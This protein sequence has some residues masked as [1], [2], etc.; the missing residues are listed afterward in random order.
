MQLGMIGGNIFAVQIYGAI[1]V[2][3]NQVFPIA[4]Q[5]LGN[6]SAVRPV[7][8]DADTLFGH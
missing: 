3:P 5:I 6:Q 8:Q 7:D 1:D 2:S 4:Q